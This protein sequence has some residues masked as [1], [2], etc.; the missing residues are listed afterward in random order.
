MNKFVD[1]GLPDKMDIQ[2]HSDHMLIKHKWFGS[3]IVVVS[4][5]VIIWNGAVFGFYS[6]MDADAELMEK[7]FPLLHVAIGIALTYYAIAGWLNK[8]IIFVSRD[9][10]NVQCKP[11][12][13]GMNKR[14]QVGDIEQLCSQKRMP[15][16]EG[17]LPIYSVH[18]ISKNGKDTVLIDGLKTS[19]QALFIE[20]EIEKYLEIESKDK[21]IGWVGY[22]VP[23]RSD[24]DK[25]IAKGSS[26]TTDE[27]EKF[28]KRK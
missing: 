13:F 24:I 1:I 8:T 16:R 27:F 4:F 6:D 17:G 10:L 14:F 20:Q 2:H 9:A 21:P 22:R 15:R 3:G 5:F 11:I 25:L 7:L 23:Q 18:I 26:L 12:P 28:M 19:E